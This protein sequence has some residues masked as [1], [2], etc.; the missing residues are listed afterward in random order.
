VDTRDVHVEVASPAALA[1]ENERLQEALRARLEEAEAL[2]RVAMLVARQHEPEAVLALVTEEVGRHLRTGM[3]MT[4]RYD[5]CHRATV[6]ASWTQP[7]I[8]PFE[9]GRQW[10]ISP[11]TALARVL[12]L[13]APVRVD[14]Y[15]GTA[16]PIA[17]AM[18]ARGVRATVAAPIWVDGELWGMFVAASTSRPFAAEAPAR[19]GAFTELVA[20][21]IANV[22]AQ[23]RLQESRARIVEAADVARRRIE[24][25][26][27]DGA[28]QRLV[29]LAL[30]LRLVAR[31]AEADT[32][33]AIERCIEDL[34]VALAEL[35]E[36][37]QGL[38]PV[39]LTDRGLPAALEM[40]ATRSHVP[41]VLDTSLDRRLPAGHE[42]ALYF[43]ALEALT[44]VAK[45]AG[46]SAA[47]VTLRAGDRWAE[48]TIADDGCGGAGVENGSGLRGL[49]D[50][51]EALGGRLIVTS[52]SAE[53][54]TVCAR[55]PLAWASRGR[56]PS[57]S[58]HASAG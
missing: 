54:T 38:H 31:S 35:R 44:N 55:L 19:L 20:Q 26:L 28:Q 11:G 22:D 57:T 25:D 17:E 33:G 4:V 5:G 18:R 9:V 13:G 43:V 7:A 56:E 8:A 48:I 45:Y 27:H 15:E 16:G 23:V 12:E 49:M 58:G 30:S 1:V 3:A 52:A 40:L 2:R 6:A 47:E 34:R 50:R 37:A 51:V 10:E 29:A 46:A 24:R 39:V 36:L 32:A 53:G 14:S 42:A 21:A 41:V